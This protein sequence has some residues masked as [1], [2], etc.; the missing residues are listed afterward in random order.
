MKDRF[1]VSIF[2]EEYM[3]GEVKM[4]QNSHPVEVTTITVRLGHM[5]LPVF[6]S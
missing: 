3:R 4:V 1:V 6:Y 2:K 5:K